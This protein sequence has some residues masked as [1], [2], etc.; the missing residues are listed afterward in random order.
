MRDSGYLPITARGCL[1]RMTVVVHTPFVVYNKGVGA[2]VKQV[3][4]EKLKLPNR[5]WDLGLSM[6]LFDSAN[7]V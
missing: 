2:V 6:I 4:E 5:K 1:R 7:I 3:D